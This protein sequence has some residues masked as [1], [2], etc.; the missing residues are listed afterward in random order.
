M[1]FEEELMSTINRSLDWDDMT[2]LRARIKRLNELT[3][4]TWFLESYRPSLGYWNLWSRGRDGSRIRHTKTL[5]IGETRAI[6][7][8]K[9]AE[10][11]A[12]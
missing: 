5:R 1:S 4:L 9:L 8:L 2:A 3:G 12:E 7:E 11:L 10:T 6:V